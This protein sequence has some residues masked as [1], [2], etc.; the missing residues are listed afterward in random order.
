MTRSVPDVAIDQKSLEDIALDKVGMSGIAVPLAIE[1]EEFGC[2]SIPGFA[3]AYVS[4]DRKAVKGIHMSRLYLSLVENLESQPLDVSS[5]K[6]CLHDFLQSHSGLSNCAYLRLKFKLPV[7]R[8]SLVSEQDGWRHYHV[9]LEGSL[10]GSEY[11]LVVKLEINY[12]ST[13]PCSA[14]LSRQLIQEN[15]KDTFIGSESIDPYR[16]SEWLGKESSVN[17]TPHSQRSIAYLTLK[18]NSD[19]K[20]L[21]FLELIDKC[22]S[23]LGTPVQAAVKRADE[24]EFARLN[25]ESLMFV[26]DAARKL[27]S[28]FKYHKHIDDFKVE[29]RHLESLHAHDAVAITTKGV[30]GGFA[31]EQSW[32]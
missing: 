9:E 13:C 14:A 25:G 29:A 7:K 4:L 28:I 30:C 26:E 11:D 21:K 15:F 22:E 32:N 3:D 5:I 24:Q 2:V 23:A 6:K 10:T 19:V 18:L 8:R 16:V 17:A 27:A 12:S 31:P 1:S 20:K